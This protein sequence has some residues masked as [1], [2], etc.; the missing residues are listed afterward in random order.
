M[1]IVRI[2]RKEA[3]SM[4]HETEKVRSD[5][6]ISAVILDY[7]QVISAPANPEKMASMAAVLGLDLVEFRALYSLRRAEYDRGDVTATEYWLEF[8]EKASTSIDFAQ[9]PR[10][11]KL[12]V[13][14]WSSV[15]PQMIRWI[16]CLCDAGLKT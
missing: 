16:E 15:N 2:L 1:R 14:T 6:P 12:D 9:I 4:S 8:A 5:G 3:A 7:G 11:R 13:E 10:L